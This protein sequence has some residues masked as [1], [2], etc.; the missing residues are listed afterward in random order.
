MRTQSLK[1]AA[2]LAAAFVLLVGLASSADAQPWFNLPGFPS[3]NTFHCALLT[4]GSVMC[5]QYDTNHWHRLVPNQNDGSY[6]TGT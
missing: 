2:G 4:D 3:G 6:R 1:V 5:H